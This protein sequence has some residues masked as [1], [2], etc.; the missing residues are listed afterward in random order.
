M[1]L[2]AATLLALC[3]A[4]AP[5][6]PAVVEVIGP[7][8]EPGVALR[9]QVEKGEDEFVLFDVAY[10]VREVTT[11]LHDLWGELETKRAEVM[12]DLMA[13][14]QQ[15][16]AGRQD[17][18]SIACANVAAVAGA[19]L[20]SATKHTRARPRPALGPDQL[21]ELRDVDA[22]AAGEQRY[23]PQRRAF[24]WKIAQPVGAYA[25]DRHGWEGMAALYRATIYLRAYSAAWPEDT[26]AVWCLHVAACRSADGVLA[27]DLGK[28]AAQMPILFGAGVDESGVLLPAGAPD[29]AWLAAHFAEPAPIEDKLAALFAEVPMPSP[30]ALSD[31]VLRLC[32]EL[33]IARPTDP[34]FGAMAPEQW[35]AKW[36]D[37]A[38][39][40]YVGLR[41]VDALAR[42][43]GRD[44]APPAPTVVIEP[45]PAVWEALRWLERR[46]SLQPGDAWQKGTSWIDPVIEAL[47]LQQ[48]GE[49][50]PVETNDHLRHLLSRF[51]DKDRLLGTT[52][53]IEGVP[54]QVRRGVPHLVRVPIRWR[55]ETKK[56]L[57]LRLFVEQERP[58][59]EWHGPPWGTALQTK[60]AAPSGR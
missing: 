15:R 7:A 58:A 56:A 10:G 12:S 37:A 4:S 20:A 3:I 46:R 8:P 26:S 43:F 49:D 9:K 60:P 24:D 41:E 40:A 30:K 34:L 19:L 55:G 54:A 59:G 38:S 14:M 35:Q 33:V 51:G 32:H 22:A 48:K 57:A 25:H 5:Q 28:L 27:S 53:R 50:L 47:E 18:A 11:N 44:D 16:C 17:A 6:Q 1:P 23:F 2:F 13:A 42:T 39:F 31:G 21:A 45:L 29:L 36:R 52:T